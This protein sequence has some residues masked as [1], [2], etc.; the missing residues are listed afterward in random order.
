[1]ASE[2]SSDENVCRLCDKNTSNLYSIFE[3][4]SS[5]Q[6][7]IQLIKECLPLIVSCQ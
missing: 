3:Q 2:I 6:Q 1:M 5:G 4:N 7:I